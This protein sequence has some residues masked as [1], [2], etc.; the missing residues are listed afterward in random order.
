MTG[1]YLSNT[2]LI[3]STLTTLL[4]ALSI[5]VP[6]R[7]GVFSFAGVGCFGIG[8]YTAAIAMTRLGLDTWG[9]ILLGTALAGL[10]CFVLGLVIQR[11][12]GLYL[13]MATVAFTLIVAVVATNGGQLTGGA[14]GIFGALGSLT[15]GQIAL[16]VLVVVA[17]LALS[18]KGGMGRRVDTVREDPELASALGINVG[19]YRQASFLV[20]GLIGGLAGGITTLLR[21]TITPAEVNFHLVV[22]ALTVIIV[23]GS[24]SWLGALIGSVILV[25]MPTVLG[26]V[27]AWEDIVYGVLVA[28]AAVFLPGGVLGLGTETYRRARARGR[29]GRRGGDL[30]AER[31]EAP[32]A[33]PAAQQPSASAV[34]ARGG[35]S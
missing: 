28:L 3:Q 12:T 5:Q 22:L 32:P 15:T 33:P 13:G 7:A 4:L 35:L 2:V 34:P 27:S 9:A 31:A 14:S 8:G 30:A 25:W 18:E 19:R 11:L 21:S 1:W 29:G 26:F 20:S 10:L 23:G 16:V 17:L 6:L 24:G